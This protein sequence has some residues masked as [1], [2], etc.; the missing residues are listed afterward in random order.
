MNIAYNRAYSNRLSSKINEPQQKRS[1]YKK[2][3]EAIVKCCARAKNRSAHT[4]I[5]KPDENQIKYTKAKQTNIYNQN[6]FSSLFFFAKEYPLLYVTQPSLCAKQQK[7]N[8]KRTNNSYFFVSE[9]HFFN[10]L[11]FSIFNMNA[12]DNRFRFERKNIKNSTRDR[13]NQNIHQQDRRNRQRFS[14]RLAPFV[15]IRMRLVRDQVTN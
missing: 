4:A 12:I 5:P 3:E 13:T 15:L 6:L 1:K 7:K 9:T 8:R 14:V 2:K 10:R 11:D